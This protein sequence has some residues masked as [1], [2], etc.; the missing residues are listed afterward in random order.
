MRLQVVPST[1]GQIYLCLQIL[2]NGINTCKQQKLQQKRHMVGWWVGCGE[3]ERGAG[4]GVVGVATG[5]KKNYYKHVQ[6]ATN[7]IP[8]HTKVWLLIYDLTF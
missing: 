1:T 6:G 7:H 3:R 5:L 4:V 8:V 2:Q